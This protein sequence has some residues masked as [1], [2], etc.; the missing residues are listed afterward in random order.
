[1]K[2]LLIV[3]G[4]ELSD[5]LLIREYN[6]CKPE[7]CIAV[8]GALD[9][10]YRTGLPLT[11][12]VGDF[13]TADPA[14]LEHYTDGLH[15]VE[16][17]CPQKDETDSELAMNLALMLHPDEIEI[18]GATGYRMD[19]ALANLDLLYLPLKKGIACRMVDEYNEITLVETRRD[20]QRTDLWKYV[21]FIPFTETVTGITLTGFKYPLTD[22]TMRK[23]QMPGL[24]VSN[25]ISGRQA[26]ITLKQGILYC[27]RSRDRRAGE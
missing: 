15:Y 23:G 3:N 26:S 9:H 24:G 5:Q 2:R 10:F 1:M 21:S 12:A 18:L 4:G 11:H 13:D 19:H 16:R 14:I 22:Y 8:D 17:H 20:F 25:E 6:A 27:I 7:W